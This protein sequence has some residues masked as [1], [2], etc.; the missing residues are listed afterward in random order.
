MYKLVQVFDFQFKTWRKAVTVKRE[1]AK[2]CI[3]RTLAY[4]TVRKGCS[5]G[6]YMYII[7]I[8]RRISERKKQK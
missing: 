2:M 1:F 8:A 4:E 5:E 7:Y 3:A 6:S